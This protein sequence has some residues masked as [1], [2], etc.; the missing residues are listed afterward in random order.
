MVT[1]YIVYQIHLRPFCLGKGFAFENSLFGAFKLTIN[2]DPDKYKYSHYGFGFDANGKNVI[3]GADRNPLVHIDNKKRDIFGFKFQKSV[4][5]GSHD[6]LVL[7]L[8]NSD[9][10][11][12]TVKGIIVLLFMIS[13]NLMQLT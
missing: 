12:I 7:Y 13:A 10:T 3:F 6:L 5:N 11:I 1:I 8:N 9:I 2:A 4:C